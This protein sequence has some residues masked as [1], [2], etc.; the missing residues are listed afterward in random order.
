MCASARCFCNALR[1]A[2]AD[3]IARTGEA[4]HSAVSRSI[5]I[6]FAPSAAEGVKTRRCGLRATTKDYRVDTPSA[7][8]F[9][10]GF[11]SLS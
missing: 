1:R 4:P 5:Y 6:T 8:A 10:S 7:R 2:V 3:A 11:V 9:L